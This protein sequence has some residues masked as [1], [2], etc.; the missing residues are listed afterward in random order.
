[1]ENWLLPATD[2]AV[3]VVITDPKK[4]FSFW[5]TEWECSSLCEVRVPMGKSGV[6]LGVKMPTARICEAPSELW[7]ARVTAPPQ[8]LRSVW[9]KLRHD[10]KHL[11]FLTPA[12]WLRK[13][14]GLKTEVKLQQE[15][16]Q[17]PAVRGHVM[18]V[19]FVKSPCSGKKR[20]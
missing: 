17:A 6:W 9:P 4:S 16:G 8:K 12:V 14:C 18:L 10:G 15:T 19:M 5:S 11:R 7:R 13:Y 3:S 20:P 1:M 2:C